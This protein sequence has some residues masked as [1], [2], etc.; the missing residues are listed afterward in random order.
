L[1]SGDSGGRWPAMTGEQLDLRF[2]GGEPLSG[3]LLIEQAARVLHEGMPAVLV[4]IDECTDMATL[5]RLRALALQVQLDAAEYVLR[6]EW[7]ARP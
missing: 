6:A 2:P 5:A 3:E 4:Y 7:A 1:A